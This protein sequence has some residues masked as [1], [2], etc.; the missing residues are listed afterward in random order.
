MTEGELYALAKKITKDEFKKKNQNEVEKESVDKEYNNLLNQ[1]KELKKLDFK[2]DNYSVEEQGHLLLEIKKIKRDSQNFFSKNKSEKKQPNRKFIYNIIKED[3]EIDREKLIDYF[4]RCVN[5]DSAFIPNMLQFEDIVQIDTVNK[6]FIKERIRNSTEGHLE[7]Y[8]DCYLEILQHADSANSHIT[9]YKEI[10]ISNLKQD[11]LVTDLISEAFEFLFLQSVVYQ[12]MRNSS[13]T[14]ERK[15]EYLFRINSRLEHVLQKKIHL[16][17][18][19]FKDVFSDFAV[20]LSKI[21]KRDYMNSYISVIDV[22]EQEMIEEPKLFEDVKK[23]FECKERWLNEFDNDIEQLMRIVLEGK[24]EKKERFILKKK[25]SI[26]IIKL[27]R[28]I[29]DRNLCEQYLQHFKA[30]YREVHLSKVKSEYKSGKNAQSIVREI[31]S[32]DQSKKYNILEFIFLREKISRGLFRETGL[33]E[34]YKIKNKIQRNLYTILLSI[35]ES[36]DVDY[37][38][39]MLKHLY[40]DIHKEMISIFDEIE[41]D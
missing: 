25:T 36:V 15:R 32:V 8:E 28:T 4:I 5:S 9:H 10:G 12:I 30:V 29:A 22:L 23:E 24:K 1:Y 21:K 14:K 17:N 38:R 3:L 40:S 34:E 41:R 35:Y 18:N 2:L 16:E 37:Q 19:S 31:S 11:I 33:I 7:K 26:S 6:Q 20:Y 13:L 39:K 27:L